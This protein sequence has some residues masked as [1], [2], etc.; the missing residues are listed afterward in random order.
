MADPF[1]Y[2]P[3]AEVRGFDGDA[4]REYERLRQDQLIRRLDWANSTAA[5]RAEDERAWREF[6]RQA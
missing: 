1:I 3:R 2:R 4:D 5:G 6:G